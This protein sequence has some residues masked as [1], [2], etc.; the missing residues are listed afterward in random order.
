MRRAI[1]H[2]L[3]YGMALTA[4][5]YAASPAD[6]Y[7]SPSGSDTNAGTLAA[8]FKTIQ[9]G[10]NTAAAGKTCYIRAGVYRE[11]VTLGNSGSSG[12]PIRFENYNGESVTIDGTDIPSLTWTPYSGNIY[13]ADI[14]G[15][16][17]N[18]ANLTQLFLADQMMQIARWPN[19]RFPEDLWNV[20]NRWAASKTGSKLGVLVDSGGKYNLAATGIDFTGGLAVLQVAH[21]FYAYTRTIT[22]HTAGSNTFTYPADQQLGYDTQPWND[23][24]YYI[25]GMG[26]SRVILETLD[27][28]GEWLLDQANNKLYLYPPDGSSP[29]NYTVRLKQ[30]NY[31]FYASGKSYIEIKGIDFFGCMAILKNSN[32]SKLED[33]D[34]QYPAFW[35]YMQPTNGDSRW[36]DDCVSITGSNAVIR[37]GRAYY[38]FNAG[39]KVDA[40]WAATA[41][42]SIV[43]NCLVEN[44]SWYGDMNCPGI[45]L[46]GEWWMGTASNV[47]AR[48]NTVRNVGSIGISYE[49]TNGLIEY[50]EVDKAC[51]HGFQDSTAIYSSGYAPGFVVRYNWVHDIMPYGSG[52]WGYGIAFRV[53]DNGSPISLYNNVMWN[54]GGTGMEMKGDNH[55][56]YNNTI[57]SVGSLIS[58]ECYLGMMDQGVGKQN[59]SSRVYNNFTKKITKDWSGNLFVASPY[60]GTN[61]TTNDPTVQF[62]DITNRDFRPASGS[63]LIDAGTNL[64]GYT[65]GYTG[66][67][68][69]IGAY[70]RGKPYWMPGFRDSGVTGQ[71]PFSGAVV[72][73]NKNM[74]IWRP[75]YQA[76]SQ[77][78]Y[79]ST[80]PVSMNLL[81]TLSG[82]DMSIGISGLSPGVTYYWRVDSTVNGQTVTGTNQSFTGAGNAAPSASNPSIS[83]TAKEGQILTGTYTYYDAEGDA[84]G[85]STFRWIRSADTTLDAGDTTVAT[86]TN[87]TVQA[88]DVGKYLFF[89]VTPVA[90]TGTTPGT[91]V[92]SSATASVIYGTYAGYQATINW[93]GT[94]SSATGDADNDGSCNLLEYAFGTNPVLASGQYRPT[95]K[96]YN[97][98]A[99]TYFE[100]TYRENPSAADLTYAVKQSS[101]LISWSTFTPAAQDITKTPIPGTNLQEVAVRYP[102]TSNRAYLRVA[103]TQQ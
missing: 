53:D 22:N 39:F 60:V 79:L 49:G 97:V 66:S 89:E 78:V 40:P 45:G 28:P 93:S 12:S 5:T 48:N 59:A 77:A 23:D 80:N 21:N 25:M 101:D 11:E 81:G 42:N 84:Q 44:A 92:A 3:I 62:E 71:S 16:G 69:D 70:E 91:R 29:A 74:L 38:S 4:G 99:Q 95:G 64:P 46:C 82:T 58:K 14:T 24:H 27:A 37:N 55:R 18:A 63:G 30:R 10:A 13:V 61:R 47:T 87:Y 50:N 32:Y 33:C 73:T 72:N 68:P 65:D 20:T 56:V 9:K 88:A 100:I 34:F 19:S 2:S 15:K 54:V 94:D 90:A 7:V 35:L 8:P 98:G 41:D 85:V 6:V 57:F 76:T 31:G 86:T 17:L 102:I 103:I 1:L 83:G 51:L 96:V 36:R 26:G 52:T 75:A 67:A 43:E